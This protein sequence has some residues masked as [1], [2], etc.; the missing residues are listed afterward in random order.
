MSK[1][2]RRVEIPEDLDFIPGANESDLFL[3]Y[4]ITDPAARERIAQA[5]VDAMRDYE[6]ARA[7]Q[8]EIEQ[9]LGGQAIERSVISRA[10]LEVGDGAVVIPGI[11]HSFRLGGGAKLRKYISGKYNNPIELDE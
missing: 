8:A 9:K 3:A 6:H 7:H 1:K 5:A 2:T 11:T 4:D 10:K